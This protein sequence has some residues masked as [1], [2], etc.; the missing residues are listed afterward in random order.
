MIH[1]INVQPSNRLIQ[2]IAPAFDLPRVAA[3][4]HGNMYPNVTTAMIHAVVAC[5]GFPDESFV[6]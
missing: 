6:M 3:T 2:P 5:T 1:P 4:A